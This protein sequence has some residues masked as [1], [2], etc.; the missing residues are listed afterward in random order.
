MVWNQHATGQRTQ[1]ADQASTCDFLDDAIADAP[2]K[3]CRRVRA[4]QQVALFLGALLYLRS[5]AS[6]EQRSACG[7]VWRGCSITHRKATNLLKH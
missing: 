3:P 7:L 4:W 1:A 5:Q 2:H 6:S